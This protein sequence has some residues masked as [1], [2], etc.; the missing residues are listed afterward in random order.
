MY[1]VSVNLTSAEWVRIQE[2]ARKQW[3]RENLSRAEIVRRYTLV[4]IDPLKRLSATERARLAH[5]YQASMEAP[6]RRTRG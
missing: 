4:G 6:R 2:A 1:C 5:E 3:P